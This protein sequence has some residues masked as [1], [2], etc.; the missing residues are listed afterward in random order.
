MT[1]ESATYIDTLDANYPASGDQRNE[2]DNHIRLVKAAIKATFPNITGPVTATQ[3]E[4]NQADNVTLLSTTTSGQWVRM[5][6]TTIS[7]APSAVDFINGTGG[8]TISTAYD[9]FMLV[10]A[11]I[12][13]ASGNAKLRLDFS[14]N[15]GSTWAQGSSSGEVLRIDTT[16]PT[17]AALSTAYLPINGEQSNA[18]ANTGIYAIAHMVRTGTA[19]TFGAFVRY[20]GSDSGR[21]GFL[22]SLLTVSTGMNAFRAYWD[23]GSFANTGSI[24]LYARKS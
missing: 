20:H 19:D 14:I 24:A 18:S 6:K 7:G 8:V 15:G 13:Q 2:G 3:T 16:T 9:E 10:F 23:S 1:V 22:H 21:G 11:N 12:T 17:S 5:A 4:L